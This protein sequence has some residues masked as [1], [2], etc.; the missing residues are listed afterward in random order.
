[1]TSGTPGRRD[2][3]HTVIEQIMRLSW[4]MPDP[5][6]HRHYLETLT[7]QELMDRVQALNRLT[8]RER[9]FE[10]WPGKKRAATELILT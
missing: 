10:F 6:A 8:T 1:M 5:Q 9:N 3:M 2:A 7:E 4:P